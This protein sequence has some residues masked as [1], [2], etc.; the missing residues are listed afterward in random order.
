MIIQRQKPF[1][2]I[3]EVLEEDKKIFIAGCSECATTCK[4]GGEEE[5]AAMKVKL[6]EQGKI[7][8]GSAIFDTAC[9][10]GEVRKKA[11]ANA[12]AIEEADSILVLAC[13]NG[14]QTIGNN[15]EKRVHPGAD[16]LFIG[17]VI[18]LGKYQEH[19]QACGECILEWTEGICPLTRCAKGLLNGPCGGYT[20]EG[21]CEVD[22]DRECAWLQIYERLRERGKLDKMRQMRA[23]KDF[24]KM[25]NPRSYTWE[26]KRPPKGAE[27]AAEAAKGAG[28]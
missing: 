26:R 10:R 25:A 2:E 14:V 23:P 20:K 5:V 17:E 24:S 13:G 16:S 12:K 27:K 6:E 3:L 18:H 9:L 7:V 28:K 4:V 22:P 1:E 19:C 11:E 21:K 15:L 8:T